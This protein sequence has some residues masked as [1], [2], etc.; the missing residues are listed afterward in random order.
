M[1]TLWDNIT[2]PFR[3]GAVILW[4]NSL[5]VANLLAPKKP[6][7]QVVDA[8]KPGHGGR[9]PAYQ[10]PQPS[11]SRSPC[12]ALNAMANHGAPPPRPLL[13]YDMGGG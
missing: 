6:E 11:D 12:P 13:R 5:A 7:G 10:P 8:G 3:F 2:Y 1:P 9:W 4:D